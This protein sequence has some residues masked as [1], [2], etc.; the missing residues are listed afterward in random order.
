[1]VLTSGVEP[2]DSSLTYHTQWSSQKVP[3]LMSVTHLSHPPHTPPP[4][5]LSLFSVFKSLLL[6]AFLS[7]LILFFL[8]FWE[9]FLKVSFFYDVIKCVCLFQVYGQCKALFYVNIQEEFSMY[10]LTTV[11]F[12]QVREPSEFVHFNK[13]WKKSMK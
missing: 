6:F 2:S 12:A 10:L 4:A 13:I 9:I 1:M 11:L 5:T 7:V 8:P 3:S